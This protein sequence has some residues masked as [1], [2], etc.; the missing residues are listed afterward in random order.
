MPVTKL[1]RLGHKD[2]DLFVLYKEVIRRGGVMEVIAKK[3]WKEVSTVFSF[4][5]TC[6]NAGY[7][8]RVNY[9]KLLY[10]FELRHFHS[11]SNEEIDKKLQQSGFPNQ[12][13]L[14][15]GTVTPPVRV[16][17]P[18]TLNTSTGGTS[19]AISQTAA[20]LGTGSTTSPVAGL[21]ASPA[22][23]ATNIPLKGSTPSLS[24]SNN[25]NNNNPLHNNSPALSPSP[26]SVNRGLSRPFSEPPD[27]FVDVIESLALDPAL[28]YLASGPSTKEPSQPV[29]IASPPVIPNRDYTIIF[30][31]PPTSS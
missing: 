31:R 13:L 10:P 30:K 2:V 27:P 3:C 19:V 9:M 16:N 29:P 25:N 28:S 21:P 1:P 20:G 8:L 26:S 7:T 17:N 4:P 23:R 5:T 18:P 15:P 6:T 22:L 24:L 12:N 14:P 11:L